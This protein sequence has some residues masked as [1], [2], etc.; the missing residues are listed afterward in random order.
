MGGM[1]PAGGSGRQVLLARMKNRPIV[2]VL[3]CAV[4]A[5]RAKKAL[6]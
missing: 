2:L 4:A 1:M 3:I 6:P 5:G